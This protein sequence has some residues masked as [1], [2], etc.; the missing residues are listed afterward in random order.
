MLS[1]TAPRLPLTGCNLKAACTCSYKHHSDRRGL[2][3]RRDELTGSRPNVKIAFER[4][5]LVT[6]RRAEDVS[7]YDESMI[8]DSTP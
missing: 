1:G 2:P 6:R 4:R 3:R 8:E 7:T 5:M